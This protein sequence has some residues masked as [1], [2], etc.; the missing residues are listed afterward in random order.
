MSISPSFRHVHVRIVK[1]ITEIV[2]GDCHSI[3]RP[4]RRRMTTY[5][6]DIPTNKSP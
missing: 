3:L 4:A 5:L 6:S 1:G 2:F